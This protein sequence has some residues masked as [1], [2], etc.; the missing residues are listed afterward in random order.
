MDGSIALGAGVGLVNAA[1][2]E[3][4]NKRQFHRQQVIQQQQN[5]FNEKMAKQQN[6][7][8]RQNAQWAYDTE[9]CNNVD[10]WNMQNAYNTPAAQM[11]R[12][13]QAGLN[14]Y[15]LNGNSDAG[16]SSAV[17]PPDMKTPDAV[18]YPSAPLD[19]NFQA[20]QLQMDSVI[21]KLY[22]QQLRDK[23]LEQMDA[24]IAKTRAETANVGLTGE[25]LELKKIFEG[26][27]NQYAPEIFSTD[28]ARR[29]VAMDR[30]RQAINIDRYRFE[31]ML[32]LEVKKVEWQNRQLA[33]KYGFDE[34]ANPLR[35]WQLKYDNAY[36]LLRN[37][38]QF[39]ENQYLDNFYNLRNRMLDGQDTQLWYQ[40]QLHGW[41]N[42]LMHS[43]K[44]GDLKGAV[45]DATNY[46]YFNSLLRGMAPMPTFINNFLAPMRALGM[47]PAANGQSLMGLFGSILSRGL[48]PPSNAWHEKEM[49][50]PTTGEIYGYQRWR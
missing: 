41:Q 43:L 20:P 32:P 16:N 46:Y 26:Y 17:T 10:L 14:P 47:D 21:D 35:L 12:L 50:D 36:R 34:A 23:Q 22:N 37:T 6:E 8:N 42:S 40:N 45:K 39:T 13:R 11:A 30:L 25:L 28:I 29:N 33:Q 9:F 49:V 3:A 48:I 7:W 4:N 15:I 31:N 18:G 1:I 27:H 38:A 24:N 19:A 44:N 5:A 2:T